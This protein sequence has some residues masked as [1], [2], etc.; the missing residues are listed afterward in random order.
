M[1]AAVALAASAYVLEAVHGFLST[2]P[3]PAPRAGPRGGRP[4][5]RPRAGALA[6]RAGAPGAADVADAADA[7]LQAWADRMGIERA[8][9]IARFGAYG[10]GL[11]ATRD[12]EPGETAVRVPLELTLSDQQTP[13]GTHPAVDDLHYTARLAAALSYE[14][15]LGS[16]SR[17]R[18]YIE[19]LPPPPR[20]LHK[21]D[22][23]AQRLLGNNTLEA[24]A[25]GMYFWRYNCW[26]AVQDALPQ[27]PA[28]EGQPLDYLGYEPF[29]T[30]LDYVCSRTLRIDL[31]APEQEAGAPGS[32][33]P[34]ATEGEGG[35]GGDG[36][37]QAGGAGAAQGQFRN[38]QALEKGGPGLGMERVMVPFLDLAN[39]SPRGGRFD[40]DA[41]GNVWCVLCVCMSVC[42]CVCARARVRACMRACV[43]VRAGVRARARARALSLSRWAAVCAHRSSAELGYSR[44]LA[45]A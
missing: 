32:E 5:L 9:E 44:S 40:V 41:D 33:Y 7:A 11:V 23:A 14:T 39:H 37:G 31:P 22:S 30:A 28:L 29:M 17:L 25:D 21:W 43:C 34:A 19:A 24:E 18:E 45:Q 10:R 13:L 2:A 16:E 8:A 38:Y 4:C 3:A 36:G 20:T 42:V 6:C 26:D 15:S 1:R 27:L 35:Q 12:L